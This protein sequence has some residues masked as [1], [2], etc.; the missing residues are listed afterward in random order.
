MKFNT[1]IRIKKGY[2]DK[3]SKIGNVHFY[4]NIVKSFYSLKIMFYI[5]PLLYN[6]IIIM[7]VVEMKY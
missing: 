7:N 5:F 1:G 3:D 4:L 2:R 6:I